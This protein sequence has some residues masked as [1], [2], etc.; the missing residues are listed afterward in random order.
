[1]PYS[2]DETLA[3]SRL[4]LLNN[5]VEVLSVPEPGE[6]LKTHIDIYEQALDTP[7]KKNLLDK[8]KE[9]FMEKSLAVPPQA[10]VDQSSGNMAMQSMVAQNN[11]NTMMPAAM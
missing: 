11:P 2:I 9:A 4:Q 10:S 8:Y 3:I 7:A 1:M 5:N 6:D